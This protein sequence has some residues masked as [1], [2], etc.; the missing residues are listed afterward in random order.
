MKLNDLNLFLIGT[1][2][3]TSYLMGENDARLGNKKVLHNW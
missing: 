3:D 2:K 1:K